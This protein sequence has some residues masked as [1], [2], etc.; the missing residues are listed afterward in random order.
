LHLEIPQLVGVSESAIKTQLS[1]Y[2]SDLFLRAQGGT[3]LYR[4][5]LKLI[6][7]DFLSLEIYSILTGVD[8]FF[9]NSKHN[10]LPTTFMAFLQRIRMAS[11]VKLYFL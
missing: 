3:I 11:S 9:N 5:V 4:E 8:S 6:K 7:S 10:P 2:K 1:A